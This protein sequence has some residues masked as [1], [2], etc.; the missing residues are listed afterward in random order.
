[1][2]GRGRNFDAIVLGSGLSGL[3]AALQMADAGLRVGVF[4]KGGGYLHFTSGC[5]DVLGRDT[6]GES[7]HNPLV[8]VE[9]LVERATQHPYVIAGRQMLLDGVQQF[10]DAMHA[11]DFAFSGD[12]HANLLVPTAAGSARRTC[13][14][15]AGMVHGRLDHQTP[16]L[17]VGFDHFRD[18]YPPFLAANLRRI[19]AFPVRHLYLDLPALHGRRHLLPIDLARALDDP[20]IRHEVGRLVTANLGD[21]ARVGFPAVLGLEAHRAAVAHLEQLIGRPIFEIPTLPPSVAGIRVSG[22]LRRQ[23]LQRGVRVEIGFW[24]RGRIEGGRATEIVVDSAGRPT[25]HRA[26][27]LVL[28]TGGTGGGGISAGPDGMLRET[29]FDLAVQGPRTRAE[30]FNQ[31]FLGPEP[32][33]ISLAGVRTNGRLQPFTASGQLVENV[34]VTASNLPNWDPVHE[35]SGEGVALAT[36]RKAATEALSLLNRSTVLASALR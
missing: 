23:L 19:C 17:I 9:D 21:A 30:W 20:A 32:Q 18:F 16:M 1:V 35:G 13:L 26:E 2:S 15:P 7:V 28:A 22:A 31:S 27:V 36:A 14:A 34:F 33:P 8:A 10:L 5:I 12:L 4:A 6:Q 29:V 3:V 11:A 24:L 25:T